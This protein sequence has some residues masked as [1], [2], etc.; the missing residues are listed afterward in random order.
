MI[1]A[2][3]IQARYAKAEKEFLTLAGVDTDPA[4]MVTVQDL[5]FIAQFEVDLAAEGESTLSAADLKKI[6]RFVKKWS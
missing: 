6:A 2:G 4:R 5:V 1:L 3:T